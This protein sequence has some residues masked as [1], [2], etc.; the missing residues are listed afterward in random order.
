MLQ[1]FEDGVIT[2][3]DHIDGEPCTHSSTVYRPHPDHWRPVWVSF[4]P[5]PAVT[6]QRY[7][8][9]PFQYAS[10]YNSFSRKHML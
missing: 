5:V 7:S 10:R 3:Q 6:E 4:C 2:A 9:L 1:G 8:S